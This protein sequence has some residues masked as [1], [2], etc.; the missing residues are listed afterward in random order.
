LSSA[1]SVPAPTTS[2]GSWPYPNG[3]LAN[4]RV[5][6]DSTISIANVHTLRKAWTFRIT[7][8][9]A[10]S[11]QH[12]GS[13]AATPIVVNGVVY[14]Q[15]LYSNVYALSLTNGT[16]LWKYYV[17]KPELSGPGPNGVAVANGDRVYGFT[18]T[19]AFALN[20]QNGHVVWVGQAPPEE[21]AG[22]LRHSAHGRERDALRREP[23]RLRPGRGY[24]LAL[25][26]TNGHLLWTF[27]TVKEPDAGVVS[28]GLGAGGA[29]ETPL[30][31][32]DDS[33]TFGTGNP[34]Q[35]LSNAIDHP[36]KQLYT[37]VT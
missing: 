32:T 12:L 23:I 36:Q 31:G 10:K 25:N 21:G 1:A 28:L 16:L 4:T 9:A 26:A 14:V 11:L 35:Y 33:V 22:H 19:H 18:P 6:T 29:W 15:D 20:A 3:N 13:L 30:V 5:A 7:G 24:L 8:K 34:Y 2:Q 37:T 17:N 27:N